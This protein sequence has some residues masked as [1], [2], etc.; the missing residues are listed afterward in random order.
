MAPRRFEGVHKGVRSAGGLR[1][2]ILAGSFALCARGHRARGMA[3][4]YL[5]IA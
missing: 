5:W 4:D 2:I 3:A 1:F